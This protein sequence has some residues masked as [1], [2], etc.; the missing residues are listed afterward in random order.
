M[1]K[2][3]LSRRLGWAF[4]VLIA[5][6][7]VLGGIAVWRINLA[8]S[9]ATDVSVKRVPEVQ[10]ATIVAATAWE[11]RASMLSW[12]TIHDDEVLRK[13]RQTLATLK[14]HLKTASD[15]AATHSDLVIL[16]AGEAAA[17]KKAAD[18]EALVDKIE[19]S[20]KNLVAQ[21]IMLDDSGSRFEQACQE[22]R[23]S[24]QKQM[25]EELGEWAAQTSGKGLDE[26]TA[27]TPGKEITEKVD[28]AA[29]KERVTKMGIV[30]ELTN[31]GNAIR[32]NNFKAQ[33]ERDTDKLNDVI[34][35]FV[36]LETTLAT[37]TPMMHQQGDIVQLGKVRESAETYKATMGKMRESWLATKE[38]SE[39][40]LITGQ[41]VTDNAGEV[42]DGGMTAIKK[43][44]MEVS[45]GLFRTNMIVLAGLVVAMIAGV[46]V[47]WLSTR[48]IA[49]P[50]REG[51]QVL[52]AAA[53]EVST[54]VSQIAAS[55]GETATAVAETSTTIDEV[56]QT[57][58]LAKESAMGVS[59][60]AQSAAQASRNGLDAMRA[61]ADGLKRIGEQVKA[62]TG[63]VVILSEKGQAIGDIITTVNDLA[64]QSNLLA[65]NASIEAARAGEQ[66]KGFAV[67]AD[68]I[69]SLAEQSKEA[70]KQVR[71]I[72]IDVQKATSAAV[73]TTEQGGKAVQEGQKLA[74][75]A[76]EAINT[77][78]VAITQAAQAAT[79]IAASS[80]QQLAGTEQVGNAMQNIKEASLQNQ[81][82]TTQLATAA[83]NLR[84][85][86][87][88]LQQLL[89]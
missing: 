73:L 85:V 23:L 68:E 39:K 11:T 27:I 86:G 35:G 32:L 62:I 3:T 76:A 19:A 1:Q 40:M 20:W 28:L 5:L 4:G 63:S 80:Q 31:R 65:V 61:S 56:R 83:R 49:G 36:E 88:N 53:G 69:R 26:K 16:K 44:A 58:Q 78:A 30:E 2:L 60:S 14:G 72:L 13:G 70:T 46:V 9:T 22:M 75:Q 79:Q 45:D 54:T 66:G 12:E 10:A 87:L 64:E 17:S 8:V 50:I 18:Y 34:K 81:A 15:L 6:M 77:L 59:D 52:V 51:A 47:A 74:D 84:D 21:S 48:A 38:C 71:S 42:V 7:C 33:N 55:A 89:G 43:A 29:L 24:Q 25:Y 67:V 57:A 37:L 82:S 41:D